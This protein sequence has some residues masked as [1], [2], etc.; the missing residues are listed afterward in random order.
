MARYGAIAAVGQSIAAMLREACPRGEFPEATCAL[1]AGSDLD[2]PPKLGL[3]VFLYHVAS[4]T[5]RRNLGNRG[6][7]PVRR[8]PVTV[9][10]HYLLS[11]WGGT[12]EMQQRLLGWALRTVEDGA[13]IP[14]T[15]LN[16]H[17]AP[18][19]ETFR[20]DESVVLVAEPL[21]LQ[22]LFNVREL[23]GKVRLPASA[24]YVARLVAIDSEL[25]DTAAEPVRLRRF[26]VSTQE[27]P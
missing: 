14:A 23:A 15:F 7:G 11:A 24:S 25:G 16:E 27:G 12:A 5:H 19:H 3:T 10:L 26:D 2:A 9:D 22:D 4:S 8:P 1:A 20:P 6:E 13:I 18:D 17:A 21:S